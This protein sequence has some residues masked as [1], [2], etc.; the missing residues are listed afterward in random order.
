MAPVT[1]ADQLLSRRPAG[2][3]FVLLVLCVLAGL[4]GMHALTPGPTAPLPTG[5]HAAMPHAPTAGHG[6]AAH[7]AVASGTGVP[8][9]S[10]AP[11]A[12][13]ASVAEP[14]CGHSAGGSGHLRH[15]DATCAAAGTVSAW[16]P[17][18]PA[19]ARVVRTAGP[20]LAGALAVATQPGR[21]PPDLA[22]LQLLRI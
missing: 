16:T 9:V 10:G 11:G 2:R 18:A 15:A 3:G 17:P 4:F 13:V 6:A 1:A 7:G 22:E 21:A 19:P 14:G 8:S 20:A 5:A 12:S